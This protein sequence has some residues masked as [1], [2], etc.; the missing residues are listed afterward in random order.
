MEYK[1]ITEKNVMQRK[2]TWGVD[3]RY[4]ALHI[5]QLYSKDLSRLKVLISSGTITNEICAVD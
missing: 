2:L 1:N 4:P 5:V 3:R